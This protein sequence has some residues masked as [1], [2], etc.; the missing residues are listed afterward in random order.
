MPPATLPTVSAQRSETVPS[1]CRLSNGNR[2]RYRSVN[3]LYRSVNDCR[4][5][6]DL[7]RSVNDLYRSV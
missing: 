5:I 1:E 4:P 7:Y 2:H 3:D 6:N